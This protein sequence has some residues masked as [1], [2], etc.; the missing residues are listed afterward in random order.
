MCKHARGPQVGFSQAPIHIHPTPCI[1]CELPALVRC[2]NNVYTA[3]WIVGWSG[4]VGATLHF[5][6]LPVGQRTEMFQN[7]SG[8]IRLGTTK[9]QRK[10]DTN[11][12]FSKC[13]II[14]IFL[15]VLVPGFNGS[16][17]SGIYLQQGLLFY[18]SA[19]MDYIG[20]FGE[21]ERNSRL[22][23]TTQTIIII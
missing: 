21:Y 8:N 20:N 12:F 23:A 19:I 5:L 7:L 14:H 15:D 16:Y 4:Q 11:E 1:N 2:W 10:K 9:Y 17:F 6:Q 22:K 18:I 3:T 13:I